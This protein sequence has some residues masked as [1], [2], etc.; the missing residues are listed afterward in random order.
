[1]T[2]KN[3][4]EFEVARYA[5]FVLEQ[6]AQGNADGQQDSAGNGAPSQP[7]S[8][9]PDQDD[10]KP[11]GKGDLTPKQAR[12]VEEYLVDLN[13]TQAAIRAGYSRDSAAVIAYENLRKPQ[14]AAAIDRALAER[15]GITRTRIVDELGRIAFANAGDYFDWGPDGVKVKASTDLTEEQRA[16]VCE[17][18]QTVTEKGGTIRV[19]LADKLAALEKLGKTLRMFTDKHEVSGAGGEPLVPEA[20]PKDVARA[21]VEILR[22]AGNAPDEPDDTDDDPAGYTGYANGG[23]PSP[24][25]AGGPLAGGAMPPGAAASGFVGPDVAASYPNGGSALRGPPA[26]D[27]GDPSAAAAG[28]SHADPAAA[29]SPPTEGRPL[30]LKNGSTIALDP[31]LRKFA[32]ISASG[33]LCGYRAQ[34]ERALELAANIQ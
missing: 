1:M 6:A 29:P 18:S 7:P 11:S 27:Q 10:L 8:P 28:S 20:S 32:V 22:E 23:H 16:V 31:L 12:F 4:K 21:I 33:D 17:V 3:N 19:K 30:R 13:G 34:F 24:A 15:P 26:G 25:S 5:A 2:D 9:P 14:I